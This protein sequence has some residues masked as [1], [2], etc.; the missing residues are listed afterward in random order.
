M[1]AGRVDEDE[2]EPGTVHDGAHATARRLGDRRRDGDL[3]A[4]AGVHERGLTGVGTPHERHEAALETGLATDRFEAVLLVIEHRIE[5]VVGHIGEGV[6]LL[7]L[8][9]DGIVIFGP[10]HGGVLERHGSP[11][12]DEAE[13]VAE[14]ERTD[15]GGCD[16]EYID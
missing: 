5:L 14:H 8:V 16:G 9:D 7:N 4:V 3:L 13:G 11:F 1:D 2:L 10:V 15:D 6:E 12:L